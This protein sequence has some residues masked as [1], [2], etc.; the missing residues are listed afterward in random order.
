MLQIRCP[1]CGVRDEAEFAYRG[2]ATVKRPTSDDQDAFVDY[3]YNRVNARG[4]HREWWQHST[5][6][7]QWLRVTR[8]TVTHEISAVELPE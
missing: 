8:H 3:V 4:W 2:D 1:F 6:C 7:R 5:G